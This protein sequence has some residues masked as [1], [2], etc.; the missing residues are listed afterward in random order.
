MLY[1]SSKLILIQVLIFL[2]IRAPF[3][4]SSVGK[5]DPSRSG[6][7]SIVEDIVAVDG[8]AGQGF[9]EAWSKQ[10]EASQPLRSHLNHMDLLWGV[11]GLAV[12]AGVFGAVLGVENNEVGYV[13]GWG[14]PWVWQQD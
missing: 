12:A 14:I 9:R 11:S 8:G 1:V 5:G 4:I 10:F 6:C 3:R 2:G 7:Y 13:V